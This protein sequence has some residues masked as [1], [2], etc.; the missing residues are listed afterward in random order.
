MSLSTIFRQSSVYL[1]GDLA[2]RAVGLLMIPIYTR[3]LTPADYGTIE[4]IELLITV[5]VICFGILATSDAMVR[6]YHDTGSRPEDA[7]AVVSTALWSISVGSA[8]LL[9]VAWLFA[10][11]LSNLLFHG[12]D[13]VPILRWAFVAMALSNIAELSLVYERLRQR[14]GF[15]VTFSLVQLLLTV[16]L[17]I[18]FICGARMGVWG[19]VLSKVIVAALCAVFLLARLLREV[20][21]R[22]S[23]TPARAMWQ[24]GNP[25]IASSLSMF[26]MH[27]ADRFFVSHYDNLTDL[28]LYSLAYKFGFLVTNLVGEPFGRSWGVNVYARAQLKDWEQYF[29]RVFSYFVFALTATGLAISLFIDEALVLLS[30]PAFYAGA[31]MVPVIALAYVFREMGDFFRAILFVDKRARLFGAISTVCAL[32]NL[33]LNFLLIRRWGAWGA[34]CATAVTW[35]AYLAACWYF[36]VQKH[37]IPYFF[38]SFLKVVSLAALIFFLSRLLPATSSLFIWLADTLLLLAFLALVWLSGYF[39]ESERSLIRGF[40][41]SKCQSFGLFLPRFQ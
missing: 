21:L 37:R 36:S 2:R 28:G 4:L 32:L 6:I 30:T 41:A 33:A 10:A 13:Q 3:F 18:A 20:G 40:L 16:S 39:P 11:P 1:V 9:G 14:A 15:F 8:A 23:A 19:F 24:F 26:G 29:A 12:Q 27:F 34:A 35:L 25:L 22:F 38:S 31:A 7:N 5:A 17:N